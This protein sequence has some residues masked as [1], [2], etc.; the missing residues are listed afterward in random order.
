MAQIAGHGDFLERADVP[1][2]DGFMQWYQFNNPRGPLGVLQI[3]TSPTGP[4]LELVLWPAKQP[5]RTISVWMFE[6][7]ADVLRKHPSYES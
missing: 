6:D 7:D 1:S 5:G 4:L 2:E 3:E